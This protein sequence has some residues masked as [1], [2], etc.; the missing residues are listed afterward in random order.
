MQVGVAQLVVFGF[1]HLLKESSCWQFRGTIS[2]SSSIW[3]FD[4]APG[5]EFPQR[6]EVKVAQHPGLM[7]LLIAQVVDSL[8]VF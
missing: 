2:V 6:S 3:G 5:V 8:R 7:T 4:K 1:A